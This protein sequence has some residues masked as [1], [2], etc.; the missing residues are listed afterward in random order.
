MIDLFRPHISK[1]MRV[2][3]YDALGEKCVT[4][5]PK[6]DEFERKF[7]KKFGLDN[8]VSVNSGTSALE[9][10]YELLGI[11]PGD[12]VITTPLTC[13]ATNIPLL[14]A[15]AKIV[16]ADILDDTLCI[17]PEDVARK[18]TDK[19]KAIVQVHLGGVQANAGVV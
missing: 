8:A 4:Q 12:E 19:T 1:E 18:V 17:D 11:G 5:G 3:A 10:A 15:G 6:V 2:V 9:L 7:C 13:T 14:R 16:W